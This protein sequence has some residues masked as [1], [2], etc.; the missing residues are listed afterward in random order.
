ML[1]LNV[2]ANDWHPGASRDFY[3]YN[4]FARTADKRITCLPFRA[5]NTGI[6][7]DSLEVVDPATGLIK[8]VLKNTSTAPTP[9]WMNLFRF[10]VQVGP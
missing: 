8:L 6:V 4:V 3:F 7:C 1:Y 5:A 9:S 2:P 10:G